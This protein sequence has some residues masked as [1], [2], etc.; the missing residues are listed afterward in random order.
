MGDIFDPVLD[1]TRS[2][3]LAGTMYRVGAPIPVPADPPG[4]GVPVNLKLDHLFRM[5][6]IQCFGQLITVHN[7]IDY[8]ANVAGGVHMGEPEN[9]QQEA[10]RIIGGRF[11]VSTGLPQAQQ[12]SWGLVSAT[13]HTLLAVGRVVDRGLKPLREAIITQQPSVVGRERS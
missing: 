3:I 6:V 8:L 7:V 4:T 9:E 5:P 1:K 10:L 12:Q 13:G 11:S 2:V